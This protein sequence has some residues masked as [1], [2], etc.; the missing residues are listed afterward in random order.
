MPQER[1]PETREFKN[2]KLAGLIITE[3]AEYLMLN[4]IFEGMCIGD[5][6]RRIEPVDRGIEIIREQGS[7]IEDTGRSFVVSYSVESEGSPL[8]ISY[9]SLRGH[10]YHLPFREASEEEALEYFL[11][12]A[13]HSGIIGD[14][15]WYF[16]E[17]TVPPS[18]E[19]RAA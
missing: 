16:I 11:R 4:P 6:E 10:A 13:Q 19:R 3:M 9:T 18:I 8:G 2:E 12:T 7:V 14:I 5:K 17:Q 15:G 1:E